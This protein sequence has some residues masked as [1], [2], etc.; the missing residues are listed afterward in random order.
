MPRSKR[1]PTHRWVQDACTRCGL[2]R[3][4][5]WILDDSGYSVMALVWSERS[6][7]I[8]VQP[9]PRLIGLDPPSPP[10]Q[11][12]EQAFGALAVGGE[13]PC[14]PTPKPAARQGSRR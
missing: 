5:T 1:K 8:R 10:T 6:G 4:E 14:V 9:F 2:H 11:T 13:P 12:R 7:D 3:R